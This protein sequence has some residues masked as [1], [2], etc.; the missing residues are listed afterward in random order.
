MEDGFTRA[1]TSLDAIFLAPKMPRIGHTPKG[2][3]STKGR[4]RH[5]LETP[6]SEPLLRTPSQNPFLL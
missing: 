3:Y 5:L 1:N 4:S 2:A 6:F